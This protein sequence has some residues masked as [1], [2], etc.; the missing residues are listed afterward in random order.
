MKNTKHA[1]LTLNFFVEEIDQ[2]FHYAEKINNLDKL[3]DLDKWSNEIKE[4]IRQSILKYKQD[5]K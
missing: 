3:K 2:P 5:N 1:E 4:H